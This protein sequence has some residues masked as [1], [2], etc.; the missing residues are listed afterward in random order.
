MVIIPTERCLTPYMSSLDGVE[1]APHGPSAGD[2][3]H[4]SHRVTVYVYGSRLM[5][6]YNRAVIFHFT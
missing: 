6:V 3:P 4:M 2:T 1:E 5:S